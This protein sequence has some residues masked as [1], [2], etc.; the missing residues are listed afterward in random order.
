[1]LPVHA[2]NWKHAMTYM[3]CSSVGGKESLGVP[4]DIGRRKKVVESE[5]CSKTRSL[6][7]SSLGRENDKNRLITLLT[8][9]IWMKLCW[10]TRR[11]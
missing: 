11:V 10:P 1:M 8:K 9:G 3:Q 4:T 7:H 6:D 2:R 5:K